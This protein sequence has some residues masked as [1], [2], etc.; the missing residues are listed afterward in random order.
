MA[1]IVRELVDDRP[2]V[3]VRPTDSV[4][5]AARVMFDRHVGAVVVLDG[6]TLK[7]IFTERDALGF[8][9]ATRRNPDVLDVGEVMTRD[10]VT[11]HPD[12]SVDEARRLML[13]KGFRHLPV[14]D[15]G[16]VLGVISL[17]GIALEA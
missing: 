3:A 2:A 11:I 15:G 4:R 13:E 17:R 7:G 14:V 6:A 16:A 12:A 5:A 9:V 10:P 1:K 8:F